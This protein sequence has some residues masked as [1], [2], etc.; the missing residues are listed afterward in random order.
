MWVGTLRLLVAPTADTHKILSQTHHIFMEV[1]GHFMMIITKHHTGHYPVTTPQYN[2][3]TSSVCDHYLRSHDHNVWSSSDTV[4]RNSIVFIM[5][6]WYINGITFK[7][8][9][10]QL[11]VK[12]LYVQIEHSY[13][14]KTDYLFEHCCYFKNRFES[15]HE[16]KMCLWFIMLNVFCS[17]IKW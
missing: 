16:E 5:G 2:Y 6:G 10:P 13:W 14:I 9:S 17:V 8:F 15:L 7:F 11:G 12:Q 3:L 1:R 4:R